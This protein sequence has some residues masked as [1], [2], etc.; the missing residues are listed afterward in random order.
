MKLDELFNHTF[1]S[2]LP[3]PD[4]PCSGESTP[5]SGES[6][7]LEG[8][9]VTIYPRTDPTL[10]TYLFK[11][12]ATPV[13]QHYDIDLTVDSTLENKATKDQKERE[14]DILDFIL[15]P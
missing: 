8:C 10:S 14:I 3:R 6:T 11:D 13:S 2:L 7:P 1:K 15:E 12:L 4:E 9:T 5:C